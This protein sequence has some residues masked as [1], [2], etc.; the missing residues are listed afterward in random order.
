MAVCS[1]WRKKTEIFEKDKTSH[2]K[3]KITE[4]QKTILKSDPSLKNQ[5]ICRSEI[6]PET[7]KWEIPADLR[8]RKISEGGEAILFSHDF[9]DRKC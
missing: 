4:F 6:K 2:Q 7:G 8:S 9:V 3:I 5:L 1:I